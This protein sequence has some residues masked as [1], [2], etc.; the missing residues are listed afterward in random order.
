MVL[1]SSMSFGPPARVELR[2][3]H[4]HAAHASIILH[5]TSKAI[6]RTSELP[7]VYKQYGKARPSAR[8]GHSYRHILKNWNCDA[9]VWPMPRVRRA[10]V[11]L[12][13]EARP[14]PLNTCGAPP[15]MASPAL[16]CVA[17]ELAN[18]L[19]LGFVL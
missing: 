11:A 3:T 19:S 8:K 18:A 10:R 16:Q 13:S 7:K 6:A 2:R 5:N 4:R 1:D 12:G 9:S 17:S 15:S 14:S